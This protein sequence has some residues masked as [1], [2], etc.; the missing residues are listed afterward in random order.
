MNKSYEKN[1]IQVKAYFLVISFWIQDVVLNSF[2]YNKL[3]LN[4]GWIVFNGL[5]DILVSS[6]Y[7]NWIKNC[8]LYLLS[9]FLCNILSSTSKELTVSSAATLTRNRPL[10]IEFFSQNGCVSSMEKDI[11]RLSMTVV[12]AS[13]QGECGQSMFQEV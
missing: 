5:V 13:P 4:E 11:F 6:V 2:R 7:F 1:T 10:T 8:I 12:D 9:F 3:W